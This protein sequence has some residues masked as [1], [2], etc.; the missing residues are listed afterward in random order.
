MCFSEPDSAAEGDRDG[1]VVMED[2]VG[3]AKHSLGDEE[4]LADDLAEY[5]LDDYDDEES[6]SGLK[7]TYIN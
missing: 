2:G 1:D 4:A 3:D 5:K 6:E 7:G